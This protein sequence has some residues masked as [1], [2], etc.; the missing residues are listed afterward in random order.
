MSTLDFAEARRVMVDGQ[1]RP[2]KVD[3]GLLVNAM[4]ML[5]RERFVPAALAPFAYIDEDLQLGNGRVLMEPMIIAR[6]VQA[7]FPVKGRKALVIGAGT[8]YGA[9]LLHECGAS[10]TA[11]EE[12]P[13]L[14]TIARNAL[15]DLAPGV[16]VAEGPLVEG[17]VAGAPYD[18]ILIEGGVR[19]IPDCCVEQL[20]RE[21]GKLGTVLLTERTGRAVLAEKIQDRLRI[22]PIFD[23]F[24]PELYPLAVAPAFRF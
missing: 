1:I 16:V 14:L 17:W 22:K 18:V 23:C 4:R 13:A 15:R 20:R 5:P 10:V 8:G 6:L 24:T 9:A 19:A 11:L 21:D 3:E 12:D 2:N 7:L